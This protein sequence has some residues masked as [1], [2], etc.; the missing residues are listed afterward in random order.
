MFWPSLVL[1]LLTWGLKQCSQAKATGESQ[2]VDIPFENTHTYACMHTCIHPT[3]KFNSFLEMKDF[4]PTDL[5]A[6]RL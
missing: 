4:K 3:I 1:V 2:E 6:V 5:L